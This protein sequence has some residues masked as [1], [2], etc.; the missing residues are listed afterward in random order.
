LSG[1]TA[2]TRAT[3]WLYGVLT[4][5]GGITGVALAVYEDTAPEGSTAADTKWIEY[6]AMDPGSDV[7]E[8]GAQRIWTE[9]AFHVRAVTRGRSTQA[10]EAIVDEIDNRLHRKSGTVSDGQVI[11]C[12]RSQDGSEA[13]E[14]WFKEG[15]EYRGL[16]G[17]YNLI[18][19]PL[20]SP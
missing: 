5:G 17:V 16:G 18:V 2:Y 15:V 12:T 10:L 8:V 14:S 9:Y 13:P 1:F 4:A 6:E 7:A 11:S 19:Q 20:P 3:R